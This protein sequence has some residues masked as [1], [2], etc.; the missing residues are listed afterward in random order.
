MPHKAPGRSCNEAGE[1]RYYRYWSTGFGA[2]VGRISF[3][4]LEILPRHSAAQ[5]R[6][7][8]IAPGAVAD[9]KKD[10]V[11]GAGPG[12]RRDRETCLQE[13]IS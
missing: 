5:S 9:W 12:L 11:G 4:P 10:R 3:A 13:G 2:W 1:S 6:C 7:V 8:D